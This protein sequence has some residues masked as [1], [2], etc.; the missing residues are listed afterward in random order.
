MVS[1]S[2][3]VLFSL[4]SFIF[5]HFKFSFILWKHHDLKKLLKA[6][7]ILSSRRAG[8]GTDDGPLTWCTVVRD[9]ILPLFTVSSYEG[10]CFFL[11]KKSK[12]F[13][14]LLHTFP[15]LHLFICLLDH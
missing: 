13:A 6:Y 12:Q 11:S 9:C 14:I 5:I 8:E 3:P 1:S 10:D 15:A 4:L 7:S 2:I